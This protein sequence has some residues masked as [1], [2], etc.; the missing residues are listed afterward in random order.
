MAKLKRPADESESVQDRAR[1]KD[2]DDALASERI[3]PCSGV[4]DGKTRAGILDQERKGDTLD[5]A[6]ES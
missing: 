4:V 6:G 5:D 2:E 3:K 1:P